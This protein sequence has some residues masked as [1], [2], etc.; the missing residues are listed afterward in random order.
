MSPNTRG[1]LR[2]QPR[3]ASGSLREILDGL[4]PAQRRAVTTTEGP[5]LILAGAGSGKTKTLTHR[6]AYLIE[7]HGV[8][9]EH[10]L[11]VTFTNKAAREMRER[12][13]ARIGTRRSMPVLGTFHSVCARLLRRHGSP[14]GLSPSFTIYNEDEART[15]MKSVITD[16]QLSPKLVLPAAVLGKIG[17]L[18]DELC[19][20]QDAR[21]AATDPWDLRVADL[22]ERY[23]QRLKELNAVDFDTLIHATVLLLQDH[24]SLRA[25]LAAQYP[26]ISVDEYQDTNNAQAALLTLLAGETRNICAVGDDAQ[27]IYGWRGARIENIRSFT[28]TFPGT[29][30]ITLEQNYRSTQAI[31]GAANALISRSA[32]VTKKRLWTKNGAGDP[33]HL[34]RA[35]DEK[36]EGRKILR[37]FQKIFTRDAAT[38]ADA[39]VLY[40]TNA[41]SRA[42]EEACLHY[43]VP[44]EIVGGLTF[45]ERK[46]VK[47]A[48][49][50]L[51][52]LHN[53][54]DEL[55]FRRVANV[56]TRGIG[57]RTV[58]LL[59][60]T[61]RAR[62]THPLDLAI[63]H[64]V[65]DARRAPLT[66]FARV[67]GE[68]RAERARL[69]PVALVDLLL[70]K[71]A[72]RAWLREES[73]R[74]QGNAEQGESRYEN[75]LELRT[76]AERHTELSDLL[77]E[78][79]LMSDV[80][81]STAR[82]DRPRLKLM[83][84]HAAKGL[85]FP[86][87]AVAGMEEGLLPH[88]NALDTPG[89][90]EE[91]RRLC[92]VALTRAKR[93]LMLSLARSRAIYGQHRETDPSRF[94]D[95][96]PEYSGEE[97][98]P[99][100]TTDGWDDRDPENVVELQDETPAFLRGERV[101]H[102]FFGDGVVES[103]KG[104]HIRV[105][106][107]AGTK[108]LDSTVAPLT[109]HGSTSSP[110]IDGELVEP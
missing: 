63:L 52:L 49:A 76:V 25:S 9:P 78:L 82:D 27:A 72:F 84:I 58:E 41:Q 88:Q 61:A 56:P 62:A 107:G 102:A 55:A 93:H 42:L 80:E 70:R 47:D 5:L 40:R 19:T 53:P 99:R 28:K 74:T 15:L 71:T 37:A 77:E 29:T 33:V 81:K 6:I 68:L 35:R 43:G 39:A 109:R 11:A 103:T 17:A 106:F 18:K 94:L 90:L 85:E 3:A 22:W 65:P 46:E 92:Y 96:L 89:G 48:I 75:V 64:V 73:E 14:L 50:Y 67:M 1:I 21:E 110:D 79:A 10:I 101:H 2:V 59:L 13:R 26:H 45:Y 86:L 8:T 23:E 38:P 54:H 36:D 12:V 32:E 31:L 24:T 108:T 100:E 7:A 104:E 30:V 4:N 98:Y 57:E 34:L 16:A 66:S 69:A 44:Y 95:D 87:V 91:E 20:V 51:R 83:T 105:K 60:A 97:G